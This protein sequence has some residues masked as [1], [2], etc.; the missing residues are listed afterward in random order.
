[1]VLEM[2]TKSQR[3]KALETLPTDLYTSFQ[4]IIS[5]IRGCSRTSQAKLSMRVLMWLHFAHRPLKLAELQH[6]LAV[7]KSDTEFD[8]DNIPSRKALLGCC[9]GLVVVDDE[10]LTVRFV[11]YTLEEYFRANSRVEF[12]IGCSYIAET[13][14]TYLTFGK[15]RQNCM[16]I[17]SMKENINKYT[18]LEYAA[19]YWGTYVKEECNDDLTKLVKMLVD[20]ESECPPCAIQVLRNSINYSIGISQKF[21]GIHATAYFGLSEIMVYF[22]KM[23]R[24]IDLK[25]DAGRTPLILAAG[26]GQEA[27]VQLLIE[28]DGVDINAKDGFFA[29][30][31]LIWAAREGH[32]AVVRLLIERDGVNLNAK[33]HQAK[34]P[35]T[36]A[37]ERGHEAAVQL[38]IER[39]GIDINAVDNYGVTSFIYAA[40]NRHEAIVQLLM[41]RDGVDINVKGKLFGR[42]APLICAASRGQEA[43]VRLLIERDDININVEDSNGWT[44]LSLA[45]QYRHEAV[46]Q[47]LIKRGGIDINAKDNQGKTALTWVTLQGHEDVV[48]LLHDRCDM[49]LRDSNI[50]GSLA[51]N[52][53][54]VEVGGGAVRHTY[55][56]RASIAITDLISSS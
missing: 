16:D 15:L 37:A 25:E 34:T 35:L 28:S 1:M 19:R 32:E 53:L 11:H 14:L 20:H 51:E 47:L 4:D 48:T 27:V 41:E 31:P 3:R 56:F 45:A 29:H 13:C 49:P 42:R 23:G 39:D 21:S 5:R 36:W 40:E 9:L 54:G 18:F 6:A 22:C 38:L 8:A 43:V 7:E 17:K 46:V 50:D 2:P 55:E 52:V 10:T 44:P 12:P 26:Y 33:D 24:N 30:T